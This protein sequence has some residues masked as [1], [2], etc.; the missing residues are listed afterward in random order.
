[1]TENAPQPERAVYRLL[2]SRRD[3]RTV[4]F[5]DSLTQLKRWEFHGPPQRRPDHFGAEWLG[6]PGWPKAEFPS[7]Y[8]DAPVFSRRLVELLGDEL[9]TAGTLLPLTV[10][11]GGAVADEDYRVYVVDTV[12][13][14]V[15]T[16]RSSRPGPT[17]EMK[18][19][20]FRPEALPTRLPA[21]RVPQ[22]P[23]GVYWNGWAAD[24]LSGLLGDHLEARLVW[25]NAPGSRPHPFVWGV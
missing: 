5:D 16:A 4:R 18:R 1:M 13:D 19:T 25:S 10:T 14:C 24:R 2:P 23:V 3:I 8:P 11:E 17:G 22:F 15:D 9:A 12:V 21:F 7:T 6:E 20:V